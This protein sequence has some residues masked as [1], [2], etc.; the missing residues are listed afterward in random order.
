[1]TNEKEQVYS[2]AKIKFVALLIGDLKET[3]KITV[4]TTAY[5]LHFASA[6]AIK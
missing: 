1:M 2:L 6:K 4:A 3:K 5:R